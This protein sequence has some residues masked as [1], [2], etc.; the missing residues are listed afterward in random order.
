MMHGAPT[1]SPTNGAVR[2]YIRCRD[3]LPTPDVLLL[4]AAQHGGALQRR[5]QP[6]PEVLQAMVLRAA[7]GGASSRSLR[8]CERRTRLLHSSDKV[9]TF[10]WRDC[11][12]GTARLLR[13]AGEAA[14]FNRRGC[15]I[16][17]ARLLHS[18]GAAASFIR[19]G[20]FVRPARLLPSAGEAASLGR[21]GC[22]I[23][24]TCLRIFAKVL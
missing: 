7:G 12:F 10:A 18:A 15:F 9:A 3:L 19:W 8:C 23:G 22:F 5:Y 16:R 2:C 20:C 4:R 24:R 13:W 6:W 11:F 17:P 21:R 14:S 1:R